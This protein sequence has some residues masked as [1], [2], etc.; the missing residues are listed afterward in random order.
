MKDMRDAGEEIPQPISGKRYS[1][2]FMA[3]IFPLTLI[4]N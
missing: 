4:N 2:K 1:G 3:P